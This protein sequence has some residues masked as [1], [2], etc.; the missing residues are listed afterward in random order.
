MRDHAPGHNYEPI[1]REEFRGG[2]RITPNART[3][4]AQLDRFAAVPATV[5]RKNLPAA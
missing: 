1:V 5:A 4:L 3:T 2:Q